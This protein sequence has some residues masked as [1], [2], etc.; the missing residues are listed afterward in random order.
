M[1]AAVAFAEVALMSAVRIVLMAAGV[2]PKILRSAVHA[3]AAII[4][5]MVHSTEA[6]YVEVRVPKQHF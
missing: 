5:P 4:S 3:D 1:A 6:S 2:R